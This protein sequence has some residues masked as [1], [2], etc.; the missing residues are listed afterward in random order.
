MKVL[1]VKTT[2]MGDV[3]HTLPAVT[4]AGKALA[5]VSFDWVVE[6]SFAEIPKMHP[7]VNKVIP[8]SVRQWRKNWLKSFRSEDWKLF[9]EGI[10][11]NKY[12]IVI[13]AQGLMK[14]ALIARM[15]N[16]QRYG[17]DRQSAREPVASFFYQ[18]KIH[19]DKNQHAIL[20][21]RQLFAKTLGYDFDPK[22]VEFGIDRS[23]IVSSHPGKPYLVFLHGTTWETKHWPEAYWCE[24]AGKCVANGYEIKLP[25]NGG[26]EKNRADRIAVISDAI[27]VLPKLNIM[28][29]AEVI[30]AATGVVTVDTGLGHLCAALDVPTVSLYGPTDPLKIGTRGQSQMHLKENFRCDKACNS[31][32]CAVVASSVKPA[33]FSAITPEKVVNTLDDLLKAGG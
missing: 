7:L 12:D 9:R 13:D 11:E 28:G 26:A 5:D 25:W 32:R 3:I 22:V 6:R 29:V 8:V 27:T 24:L 23:K 4:D 30:A 16:G 21:A 15:A 18:H 31:K 19:V 1:I 20:R 17:F 10:K 33:C 14:S 2:S